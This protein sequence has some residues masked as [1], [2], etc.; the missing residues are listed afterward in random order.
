MS[1]VLAYVLDVGVLLDKSHAEFENYSTVYDKKY[2]YF[3]EMQD[4]HYDLSKAI[5]IANQYVADGVENT[6]AVITETMIDADLDLEN[7]YVEGETYDLNDVVF[8]VA[9]IKNELVYGF[10]AK[11]A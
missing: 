9:K 10:V 5:A 4:Y 6:Y 11:G 2:G 8:S 1:K 3:D 7:T